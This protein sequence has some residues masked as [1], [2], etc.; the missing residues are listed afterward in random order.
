MPIFRFDGTLNLAVYEGQVGAL[1]I[2]KFSSVTA[3]KGLQVTKTKSF[4]FRT[5]TDDGGSVLASGSAVRATESRMLLTAA[6][7]GDVSIHGGQH[8]L[9]VTSDCSGVTGYMG[10]SW[11]HLEMVSGAKI[12]A[13]GAVRAHLECPSGATIS[14]VLSS[15]LSAAGDI[16]GTH[17]GPAAVIHV[18]NPTAGTFDFFAVFGSAPGGIAAKSTALSGLTSAYRILVKTPDGNTGYIPIMATW[19]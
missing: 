9:K 19:A 8:H 4:M 5:C 18:P 2:G 17:T 3:G 14:G 10:G 7:T 15:F 11:G 16:S 1:Q 12:N 6:Q 13:A